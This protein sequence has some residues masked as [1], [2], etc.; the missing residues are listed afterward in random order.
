P[1]MQIK[2]LH[3]DQSLITALQNDDPSAFQVL[4]N[5]YW[6]D[7]YR[8]AYTRLKDQSEAEDIVQ[9]IFTDIWE[10]R[11]TLDIATSLPGY[12]Q[13]ALKFKIIR[14]LSR[15]DLHKK[16]VEHLLYRMTEM[17]TTILDVLV[18]ADVEQ[19]LSQA[20]SLFP[21]NMRKIFVLRGEDYSIREI[22]EALGLAEQTVKNNMTESLR[23]LK[24]VLSEKHPDITGSLYTLLVA[25]LFV[26]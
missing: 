24:V 1:G 8:S 2:E 23:R 22:A 15:A 12:L 11:Y 26:S 20:I 10:R 16:A 17:E 6:K 4:F 5:R 9:D 21:E 13:N 3:T 14:M 19:T 18:I 25:I 7:L